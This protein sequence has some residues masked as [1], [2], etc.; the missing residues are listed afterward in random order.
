M[1]ENS[2]RFSLFFNLFI[3]QF[4]SVNCE[5]KK[6]IRI[7]KQ[8]LTLRSKY[9]LFGRVRIVGHKSSKYMRLFTFVHLIFLPYTHHVRFNLFVCLH[10][11][12]R[13]FRSLEF[14]CR[15]ATIKIYCYLTLISLNISRI[16]LVELIKRH[17]TN[18]GW[19]RLEF[20]DAVILNKNNIE[21][22]IF[23][24]VYSSFDRSPCRGN[25]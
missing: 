9:K 1:K 4:V 7:W 23:K 19:L 22:D 16:W 25:I 10:M 20:T 13:L 15:V 3:W 8:L 14:R 24:C 12:E 18:N 11:C 6:W 17:H 5:K 2:I 21:K